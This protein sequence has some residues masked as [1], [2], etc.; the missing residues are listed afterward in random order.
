ML[1]VGLATN[2]AQELPSMVPLGRGPLAQGEEAVQPRRT[3]RNRHA[4]RDAGPAPR[5]K[6]T[7]PASPPRDAGDAGVDARPSDGAVDGSVGDASEDAKALP[8]TPVFAGRYLGPDVTVF[9]IAGFP[10]RTEK[11]PNAK[12]DVEQKS[13][14]GLAITLIDSSNGTPICT[15]NADLAGDKSA[16]IPAGQACFGGSGMTAA[17]RSGTAEFAGPRLLLD[18]NLDLTIEMGEEQAQGEIEYHFDGVRK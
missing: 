12:T 2:C 15:L 4:A 11:D 9:R 7:E 17:L 5:E 16:R 10:D 1:L 6:T 14:G 3:A 18:L 13:K 8:L